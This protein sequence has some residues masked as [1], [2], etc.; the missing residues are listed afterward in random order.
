MYDNDSTE[1]TYLTS[2]LK[3]CFIK[4][5]HNICRLYRAPAIHIGPWVVPKYKPTI[6]FCSH[7]PYLKDH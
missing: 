1:F 3:Y 5:H 6:V 4:N 7:D 2:N